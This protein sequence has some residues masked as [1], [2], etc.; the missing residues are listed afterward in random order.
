MLVIK[1]QE[2]GLVHYTHFRL[3]CR[4][5]EN[6][7]MKVVIDLMEEALLQW[8]KSL[9]AMYQQYSCLDLYSSQQILVLKKELAS[10]KY[11]PNSSISQ[12]LKKVLLLVNPNPYDAVIHNA[13]NTASKKTQSQFYQIFGTYSFHFNFQV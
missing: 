12:E 10:I 2:A 4:C 13:L 7:K 11:K 6:E 3:D 8:R 9:F 5:N 1:L